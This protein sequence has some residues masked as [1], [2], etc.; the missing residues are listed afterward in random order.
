MF[1]I[2]GPK[3]L[4][5]N[6][7]TI[8]TKNKSE[9]TIVKIASKENLLS[10][11]N[12]KNTLQETLQTEKKVTFDQNRQKC[13]FD[14]F[15]ILA[16]ILPKLQFQGISNVIGTISQTV[17]VKIFWYF[18]ILKIRTEKSHFRETAETA[19]LKKNQKKIRTTVAAI[20]ITT[21]IAIEKL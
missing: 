17:K 19:I 2:F 15:E 3:S 12:T 16:A 13:S 14:R 8:E 9:Q 10:D 5:E 11:N 18:E 21:R 7:K 1:K 6:C 4:P 20:A